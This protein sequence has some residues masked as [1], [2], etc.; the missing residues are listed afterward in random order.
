MTGVVAIPP[1]GPSD[2]S[3]S[4]EPDSSSLVAELLIV[5]EK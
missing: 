5:V 2:V 3:V 4:V 1:S